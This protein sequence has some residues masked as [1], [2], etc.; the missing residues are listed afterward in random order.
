MPP[1]A[2]KPIHEGAMP[3][4]HPSSQHA[5]IAIRSLVESIE[6]LGT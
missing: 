5:E 6:E 4:R 2:E 1:S 3:D